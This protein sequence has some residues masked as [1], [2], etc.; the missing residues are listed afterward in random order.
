VS[1]TSTGGFDKDIYGKQDRSGYDLSIAATD[2][3]MREEKRSAEEPYARV[4]VFPQCI[5]VCVCVPVCVLSSCV[6][7]CY[8]SSKRPKL[9]DHVRDVLSRETEEAE[10]DVCHT[11]THSPH[12]HTLSHTLTHTRTLSLTHTNTLSH[13]LSLTL[14][15]CV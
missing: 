9:D 12:T 15:V 6:C 4:C 1:L 8:R 3:D 7:V 10:A 11:H 5:C 2:A 14:S 13:T